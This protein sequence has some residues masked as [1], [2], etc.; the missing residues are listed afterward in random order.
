MMFDL[1]EYSNVD[2]YMGLLCNKACE[3]SLPAVCTVPVAGL[4]GPAVNSDFVFSSASCSAELSI[5]MRTLKVINNIFL[6]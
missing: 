5:D 4:P 2:E 3:L 1:F 6:D